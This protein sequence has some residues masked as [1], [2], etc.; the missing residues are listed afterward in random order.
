MSRPNLG[1][2]QEGGG[3][4]GGGVC[5]QLLHACLQSNCISAVVCPAINRVQPNLKARK[6]QASANYITRN[7]SSLFRML[8]EP[9]L[10]T[11]VVTT[12][13][14]RGCTTVQMLCRPG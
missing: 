6:R 10:R 5:V 2:S 12:Q 13:R 1:G 4:G 7:L 8:M 9:T 3:G 14:R 11:N